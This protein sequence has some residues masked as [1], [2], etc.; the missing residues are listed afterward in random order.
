MTWIQNRN[1]IRLPEEATM[2]DYR[3]TLKAFF[4]SDGLRRQLAFSL[5]WTTLIPWGILSKI[6]YALGATVVVHYVAI[7]LIRHFILQILLAK[8]L[9]FRSR[10][11][12]ATIL[13]C[14][15]MILPP[16]R[17]GVF[18][19]H[20]WSHLVLF[21]GLFLVL[22]HPQINSLRIQ[23][24][25]IL[26]LLCTISVWTNLPHLLTAWFAV[27]LAVL[28]RYMTGL[29]P[30][31]CRRWKEIC[32]TATLINLAPIITTAL[33]IHTFSNASR[34]ALIFFGGGSVAKAIQGFGQWW[35]F[36]KGCY[37]EGCYQY[38]ITILSHFDGHRNLFRLGIVFILICF[39]CLTETAGTKGGGLRYRLKNFSTPAAVTVLTS[40]VLVLSLMGRF[41]WYTSLLGRLPTAFSVIR[42][43]YAKFG[44]IL[45]ILIYFAFSMIVGSLRG[46]SLLISVSII[47]VAVT[48][49][50]IPELQRNDIEWNNYYKKFRHY[51]NAEW[52]TLE[53]DAALISQ[54]NGTFCVR[55]NRSTENRQIL[56]FLSLRFPERFSDLSVLRPLSISDAVRS[57]GMSLDRP[58]TCDDLGVPW[59]ILGDYRSKILPRQLTQSC[60]IA[61]ASRFTILSPQCV[62]KYELIAD[63]IEFSETFSFLQGLN[64]AIVPQM[65]VGFRSGSDFKMQISESESSDET[66]FV[67]VKYYSKKDFRGR[68]GS[69]KEIELVAEKG[70]VPDPRPFITCVTLNSECW[71][72]I[73]SISV[74]RAGGGFQRQIDWP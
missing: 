37:P 32:V 7:F 17:L 20:W 27:P 39:T 72:M 45:V 1:G 11:I 74:S 28:L 44:T 35:Y 13:S 69:V 50:A 24:K 36:D 59:L 48:W 31:S 61:E 26:L 8:L 25:L 19:A 16:I 6:V 47:A 46:R 52:K 70:S 65:N 43:P 22:I 67:K 2:L 60:L 3:W 42:E 33:S 63:E 58:S 23:P 30:I 38:D 34:D 66:Y 54:S 57:Q 21:T 51:T 64:S 4:G 41:T 40:F 10:P 29:H 73:Y 12:V 56:A 9:S 68:L 49:A 5:Q 15:L 62:G 14:A 53:Q 71:Y 55:M 18:Y